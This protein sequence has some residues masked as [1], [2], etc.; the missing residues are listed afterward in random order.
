MTSGR[1]SD[2]DPE[3]WYVLAVQMDQN[4]ATDEAFYALQWSAPLA[5]TS[6]RPRLLS[7]PKPSPAIRPTYFAHVTPTP[8]NLVSMD[9]NAARRG[10]TLSNSC[11]R[12]GAFGHWAKDCPHRFDVQ[13]MDTDEL[14]TLLENKLAAKDI[15][16]M[17]PLIEEADPVVP[18][19]DF[20]SS[21]G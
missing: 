12:C 11:C 8:G 5:P 18:A 16:P 4:R 13:H 19:E 3:A 21:S 7:A 2:T 20:V 15:V 14:Q 17:R 6:S 10:K 1:P 9:I